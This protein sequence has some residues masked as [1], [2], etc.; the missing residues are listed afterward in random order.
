LLATEG[1]KIAIRQIIHRL[2]SLGS[3]SFGLLEHL[4][5][6]TSEEAK[7]LITNYRPRKTKFNYYLDQ[8]VP[9][10]AT[11]EQKKVAAHPY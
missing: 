11:M 5:T 6:L 2:T 9:R 3:V 4:E 1:Q 10:C 7:F 8:W